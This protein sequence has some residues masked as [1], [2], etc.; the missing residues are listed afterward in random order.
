M[1]SLFIALYH[2]YIAFYN[3]EFPSWKLLNLKQC[4]GI[5]FEDSLALKK[6]LPGTYPYRFLMYFRQQAMVFSS[7]DKGTIKND[8]EKK[9]WTAYRISKE[10]EL[11]KWVLSSVQR[12]LKRFNEDGSMKRRTGSG[13]PVTVTTDE[14]A[15]LAEELICSQEDFPGTHKSPHEIARDVGISRSS[16]S[17]LV[18]RRKINQFKR[19]KTSHM[20]NG[21]RDRRTIRS[22]N[23]PI[24]MKK[25]LRLK[26]RQILKATVYFKGKK[27]QVPDENLFHQKDK[28][29][30]K[31][32]VSA[33]LLW[34]GATKPFFVNGCGVKMNAKTYKLH[35]QKE[36][37]SDAQRLYKHKNWIFVQDNAPSHRSNLV[38]GFL[39]ETLNSRFIKTHEWP[40]SLPDCNPL[41]YYFWN[42]VK[43][44]VY[45]N[46]LNKPF[47]NERELKKRFESVWKDTAFSLP[48]I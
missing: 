4:N 16:V 21:T 31:V 37:L 42:K 38:Q 27:D 26:Y 11:K 12:L 46:R 24:K 20:N 6:W 40:P 28:Q 47:E 19:M 45:E 17:R 39:Q 10:H 13:R 43:E 15:E 3:S 30:I 48:Q 25:T 36:L 1:R 41:D 44:K 9:G 14:N 2:C 22:K 35:L 23:L 34:N 33:C 7:E 8:Y 18:K 32:M 5:C 29:S